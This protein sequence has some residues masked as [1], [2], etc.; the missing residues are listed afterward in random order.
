[1]SNDLPSPESLIEGLSRHP[2][3]SLAPL[4]SNIDLLERLGA[5]LGVELLCKRDD[6]LALAMGGNKV[7][8]L[9][10][11]CGAAG[12]KGADSLLITG[13]I[14][15]N[16]VRLTAAAARKLGWLPVVQLEKRVPKEDPAYLGS[17]NVLLDRLLGA[18]IHYFAEGEDEAAADANLDRLAEDLRARGRKPFA[19]H[20]GIEHPPIGGL[21]YV[22]AAAESFQQLGTAASGITHAVVPS[23]SGLTHAGFLVGAKALGWKIPVLGV[24]VRRD[25][26][27]QRDRVL[28]RAKE[29]AELIGCPGLV[30]EDDIVVDDG[31]LFPGYGRLNRETARGAGRGHSARPRLQ[32]PHDGGPHA[33]PKKRADP[34]RGQG[35]LHSHRRV[36]GAFR[37]PQRSRKSLGR[38]RLPAIGRRLISAL[39]TGLLA[40]GEVA[41]GLYGPAPT[42]HLWRLPYAPLASA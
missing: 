20:L 16:F 27:A 24:C 37:I 2:R 13:A 30:G 25:A 15:S 18:E 29:I 22:R 12:A 7:R 39:K 33:F 32:R 26:V 8:Q 23:G 41:N 3:A 17:G 10:Y 19:I 31:V 42:C 4:P 40:P 6:A 35:P 14:Q 11:Y 5:R 9:E 34:G 21:G 38:S 28:R 36:S 1:L